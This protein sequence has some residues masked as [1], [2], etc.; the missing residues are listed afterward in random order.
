MQEGA[1]QAQTRREDALRQTRLLTERHAETVQ[2]LAEEKVR[3][4]VCVC[5]RVAGERTVTHASLLPCVPQEA[6]REVAGAL[7]SMQQTQ[8]ARRK[9][10]NTVITQVERLTAE[11]RVRQV[12]SVCGRGG[13]GCSHGL[14]CPW[15]TTVPQARKRMLSALQ[16]RLQKA[17]QSIDTAKDSLQVRLG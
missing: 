7:Q 11:L 8:A 10:L 16:A 9:E 12:F 13:A 6:A 5:A 1:Q 17:A 2:V 4:R 3:Q 14:W 15:G